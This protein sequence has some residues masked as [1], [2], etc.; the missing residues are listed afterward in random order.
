MKNKIREEIMS[1]VKL[2]IEEKRIVDKIEEHSTT[3]ESYYE[4]IRELDKNI[5]IGNVKALKMH[6]KN[7][8]NAGNLIISEKVGK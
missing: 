4:K 7:L 5:E 3:K 6:K 8:D 1:I 2:L